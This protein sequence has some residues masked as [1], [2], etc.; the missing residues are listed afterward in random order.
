MRALLI[1]APRF[2]VALHMQAGWESGNVEQRMLSYRIDLAGS[3]TLT[4][5]AAS[6]GDTV[7]TRRVPA[8]YPL[9]A[10]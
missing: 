10:R 3:T 7:S 5:P 1:F 9:P 6:G 2:A 8:E 4:L